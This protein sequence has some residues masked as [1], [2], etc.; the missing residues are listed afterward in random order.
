MTL[1]VYA[2]SKKLSLFASLGAALQ[3]NVV[4]TSKKRLKFRACSLINTAQSIRADFALS[5]RGFARSAVSTV[6][7]RRSMRIHVNRM[8]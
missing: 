4:C 1:F 7:S 8:R 5:I 2:Y 6:A 3:S